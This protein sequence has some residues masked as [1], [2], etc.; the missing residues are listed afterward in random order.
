V[1]GVAGGVDIYS[2]REPLGVVAGIA[3][4]NFPAM[5]PLWMYP[6]SITLGNTYVL[7]PSEKV[8]GTA[9]ILIDLLQQSGVPNGVVNVV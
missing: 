9:E 7:K 3:P 1:Q 4:F 2:Y 8:A 6:L 5:I